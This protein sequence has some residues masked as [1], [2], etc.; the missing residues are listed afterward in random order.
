MSGGGELTIKI[1]QK[2]DVL[3]VIVKTNIPSARASALLPITAMPP[4]RRPLVPAH[5]W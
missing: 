4:G 1:Y 2:R 3:E 5:T